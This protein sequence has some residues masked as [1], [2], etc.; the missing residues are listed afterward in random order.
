M[1]EKSPKEIYVELKNKYDARHH[2]FNSKIAKVALMRIFV[3][4]AG[5]TALYASTHYSAWHVLVVSAVFATAFV[6]IVIWHG[7]LHK[8][9]DEF[10]RL[11]RINLNEL[12]AMDGDYSGFADG[13]E[14]SHPDHPFT[15][16]L[17]IFGK[18]SIFQYINRTATIPG[19]L[20]LSEWFIHPSK[21]V[22]EIKRR[23]TAIDDLKRRVSW[24]QQFQ[25]V[26]IWLQDSE[27][28]K[29]GILEWLKM[30]SIF[31]RPAYRLL[32]FIIPLM[33]AFVLLMLITG[34]ISFQ[35]FTFYLFVPLGIA[36][37]RARAVMSKH[38]LLSKKA[39]MLEKY[40]R[41]IQL[42]ESES[43]DSAM[44]KQARE[45][46]IQRYQSGNAL[47]RLAKIIQAFDSR[48]NVFGWVILNY[49]LL[50][51]ILQARRL[52]RWRDTHKK[53]VEAWFEIIALFDALGSLSCFWFNHPGYV[54]PVPVEKAFLL[55][56]EDCAHPLLNPETRV[57]NPVSF[58]GWKNFIIVTGANMAGKST[59][60]RT[61][62][63]NFILAMAGAPVCAKEF[64]FSPAQIFTS[65]RTRDNLLESES[66]FF[67]ELKRLKAI[68]DHLES[69]TKL[70]IVL[71]EILKGTNSKDKQEGSKALLRQLIRFDSSGLIATHDLKLGELINEYPKN[72]RN[73]RFE[74][75]IKNDELVFDYK[76]KDGISQNLNATFLMKK[77]GITI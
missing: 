34:N 62:A 33:S 56:A 70:F 45:D 5:I 21:E 16:D 11:L 22:E 73:K 39:E 54:L 66:Y 60:L 38:A 71:D 59:Y 50:W 20:K 53:N 43:F 12:K 14:F 10:S 30:P 2:Q 74:V 15:A 42:I 40:G 47:R 6:L 27:E 46:M 44:L 41:L 28:D 61:V 36:L 49:F 37:S 48:L 17:D 77:M 55:K 69:G 25:S 76:L 72:I 75:E 9:R 29:Q 63:V 31:N 23:H 4:L 64:V 19:I 51:D 24:R 26:G 18:G 67:A 35:L 3:F 65:I 13:Q 7:R 32:L 57:D 52:E 68:I 58:D 1:I 8:S